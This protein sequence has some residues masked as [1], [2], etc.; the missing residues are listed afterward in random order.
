[1]MVPSRLKS[2]WRD[3]YNLLI[4]IYADADN[5]LVFRRD[6]LFFE[7]ILEQIQILAAKYEQH[8]MIKDLLVAVYEQAERLWKQ[9]R[10]E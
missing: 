1:M 7:S 8:P 9:S 2:M 6:E 5:N 4:A 10:D 3:A